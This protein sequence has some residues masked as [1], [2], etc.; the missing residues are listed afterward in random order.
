MGRTAA[1]EREV[2]A[3]G[4]EGRRRDGVLVHEL[5]VLYP[6][7]DMLPTGTALA[8]PSKG[9]ARFG[10]SAVELKVGSVHLQPVSEH[11][12]QAT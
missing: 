11:H 10:C 1:G 7:I 9:P 3:R 4:R 2:L 8:H 12:F 5:G 6:E